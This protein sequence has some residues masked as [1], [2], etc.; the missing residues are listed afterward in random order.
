MNKDLQKLEELKKLTML[1]V[2]SK[3]RFIKLSA[4]RS[5]M[6]HQDNTPKSIDTAEANLNWHAMEYDKL[7]KEVHAA[8]VDCGIAAPK[9]D[10]SKIEYNPSA[11]HKYTHQ[12]R[13]PLCRQDK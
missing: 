7:F 8:S 13:I 5:S 3:K 10:Y 9:E 1:L 6:S 12:P 11:W 2:S 4:R